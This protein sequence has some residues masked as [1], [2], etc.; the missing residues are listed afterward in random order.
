MLHPADSIQVPIAP[1]AGEAANASVSRWSAL[2][3][4]SDYERRQRALT[5][6][7]SA[8][9]LSVTE[10]RPIR[11]SLSWATVLEVSLR[12]VLPASTPSKTRTDLDTLGVLLRVC[13][14]L[15]ERRGR[16][17]TPLARGV[18]KATS[19]ALHEIGSPETVAGWDASTRYLQSTR[20]DATWTGREIELVATHQPLSLIFEVAATQLQDPDPWYVTVSRN[21]S[22]LQ[23]AARDLST[24][25]S[26]DARAL[27]GP[28]SDEMAEAGNPRRSTLQHVVDG[29][30]RRARDLHTWQSENVAK[31]DE[32]IDLYVTTTLGYAAKCYELARRSGTL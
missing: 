7:L 30:D 20:G 25:F 13:N 11:H 29:M 5:E 28:V 10:W 9:G 12:L 16:A 24:C 8:A 19:T 27:R 15:L 3:S 2:F 22:A 6:R 18:W 32:D 14:G 17:N 31:V 23:W 21:Y 4:P 26:A 1:E